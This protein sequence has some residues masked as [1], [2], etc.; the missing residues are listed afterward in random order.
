MVLLH[1]G[2]FTLL[3]CGDEEGWIMKMRANWRSVPL[4]E[5]NG[6][7][8]KPPLGGW[9]VKIAGTGIGLIFSNEAIIMKIRANIVP[10]VLS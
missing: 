2:L 7:F 10:S 4:Y 1:R 5:F 9:G 8:L 6:H 3:P